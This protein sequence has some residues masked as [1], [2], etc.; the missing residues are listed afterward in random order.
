MDENF[1]ASRVYIIS[2]S[3][4]ARNTSNLKDL[5]NALGEKVVGVRMGMRPHT[6]MS[7][8]LEIIHDA[9]EVDTDLIVTLG[10]GSLTDGTKIVAFVS[11]III[12]KSVVHLSGSTDLWKTGLGQRREDRG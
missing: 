7:E 10:G 12:M 6:F 11:A 2:S 5:E 9:Q 3:S 1:K 4:L 8:V